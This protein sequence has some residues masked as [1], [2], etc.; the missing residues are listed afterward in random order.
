MHEIPARKLREFS[1]LITPIVLDHPR[2]HGAGM[3][4]I[5]LSPGE[6]TVFRSIEELAVAIKRGVVTPRARIYHSASSKWLPIQFHPHYKAALSMPLTQSA[7][8]AG[9][10]VKP[11]S[12][13]RL[14]QP[15]EPEPPLAASAAVE[16]L[17][18]PAESP[19]KRRP[20]KGDT[21]NNPKRSRRAT[22]PRRQLRIA[23]VGALLIGGAQ[24][25]LSA[26]L[27]SRA[28]SHALLRVQRHLIASPTETMHRVSSPN[29]AAMMPVAP[30]S[31]GSSASVQLEGV[32]EAYPNQAPSFGGTA[33]A[34]DEIAEAPS[35]VN[36]VS[37]PAPSPDSL[38]VK[39][40]DST[41]NK[42]LKGILRSVS[43]AKPP[44]RSAP[45]R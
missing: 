28:D 38:G 44:G 35:S 10:P 6:E 19:S 34:A 45:S 5:E 14:E 42:P 3:Y 2:L 22:K 41:N 1:T 23:L 33:V 43:G 29:S 27:F 20:A 13:L 40:T 21:R 4:R 9:P 37:A 26:E 8:V 31:P 16:P 24:W 36:V 7:L 39:L 15:A 25:V 30:S 17:S 11:L 12:T 32:T 18:A